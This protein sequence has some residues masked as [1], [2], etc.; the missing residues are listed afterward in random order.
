MRHPDYAASSERLQE[1]KKK[2]D[3]G[4]MDGARRIGGQEERRI[5]GRGKLAR[6]RREITAINQ[7][8]H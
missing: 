4:D 2:L 5:G 6:L 1:A 8:A 7:G 3:E